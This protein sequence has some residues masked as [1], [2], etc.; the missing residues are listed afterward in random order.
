MNGPYGN[1]HESGFGLVEL[2][3]A[4]VIG[5]IIIGGA[6]QI[7][8][9][10]KR[11]HNVQ[12]AMS[13]IQE[14]GRFAMFQVT[15]ALRMAGYSGCRNIVNLPSPN[16]IAD[17]DKDKNPDDVQF[18]PG[19][20]IQGFEGGNGWTDKPPKVTHIGGTDVITLRYASGDG[21]TLTGNTDPDNANIQ[22]ERIP[23]DTE[24]GD[25]LMIT[26][27]E[28][29]DIFA[30]T[31]VSDGKKKRTIAH[32]NKGNVTNKLSK[33]YGPDA[34]ILKLH[35]TTYFLGENP[36]DEPAL[37]RI[38]LDGSAEELV[39]GVQDMQILY[40]EDLD[41]DRAADS[42]R[43]AGKVSDWS[44]VQSIRISMLM[45]SSGPAG[46]DEIPYTF[47]GNTVK[48]PGDSRLRKEFTT[49]VAVRNRN[50]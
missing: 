13:E 15:R 3:I 8:I 20:V 29:M 31:N 24:A 33:T 39:T 5:L 1:R 7:F 40:G 10:N 11:T 2:M 42:F 50:P 14:N 17:A 19:R 36:D 43:N 32:S 38:D 47:D 9:A 49:N 41:N 18:E 27:C 35:E 44:A 34:R 37:Y 12:R 6:A 16:V 45:R 26:D 28:D 48:N 4:M 46:T 22:V 21:T 30:A 25:T 23:K